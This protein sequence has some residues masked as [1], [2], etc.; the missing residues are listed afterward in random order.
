MDVTWFCMAR[1]FFLF[2]SLRNISATVCIFKS[3]LLL[4]IWLF[5]LYLMPWRKNIK[6]KELLLIVSSGT[7]LYVVTGLTYRTSVFLSRIFS[8]KWTIFIEFFSTVRIVNQ[9][10]SAHAVSIAIQGT[11]ATALQWLLLTV[12]AINNNREGWPGSVVQCIKQTYCRATSGRCSASNTHGLKRLSFD[13]QCAHT[14]SHTIKSCTQR[15]RKTPA[16]GACT[17]HIGYKMLGC[18]NKYTGSH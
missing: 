6:S 5:K 9:A 11:Q 3:F 7:W 16:H 2:Q 1:I 10:V 15:H 8:D 12:T 14:V 4:H 13:T 18:T 17:E